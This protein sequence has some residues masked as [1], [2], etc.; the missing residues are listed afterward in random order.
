MTIRFKKRFLFLGVCAAMAAIPATSYARQD[1]IDTCIQAFVA[2]ELPKGHDIEI[3]KRKPRPFQWVS[4][5][6]AKIQVHAKG[7]F[8]GTEYGSAEC[9]MSPKGELVAMVVKGERTRLAQAAQPK[10]RGG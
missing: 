1:A 10:A 8:S 3:V 5:R 9:Q 4:T 6:P 2:E 7:K